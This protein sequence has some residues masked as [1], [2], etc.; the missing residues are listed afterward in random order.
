MKMKIN[1]EKTE[2]MVQQFN[3]MHSNIEELLYRTNKLNNEL[4]EDTI[5]Q[6]SV[7]FSEISELIVQTLDKLKIVTQKSEELM[8]SVNKIPAAIGEIEAENKQRIAALADFQKSIVMSNSGA[9]AEYTNAC[10]EIQD[11]YGSSKNIEKVVLDSRES[12][13]FAN[14]MAYSS[15]IKEE[16]GIENVFSGDLS[17]LNNR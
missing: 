6:Q 14:L 4:Y 12:L 7:E 5:I 16:Y 10:V 8:Y 3:Q 11:S 9:S 17:K 15:T 1:I 13:K 2:V